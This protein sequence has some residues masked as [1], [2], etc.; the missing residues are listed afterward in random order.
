MHSYLER[1][2]LDITARQLAALIA[3]YWLERVAYQLSTHSERLRLPMWVESNVKA[4]FASSSTYIAPIWLLIAP[5]AIK[6][7]SH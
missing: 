6:G 3:A 7:L 1:I 5:R 4:L 2:D